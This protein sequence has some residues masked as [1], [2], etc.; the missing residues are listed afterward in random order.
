MEDVHSCTVN[1]EA[2][3]HSAQLLGYIYICIYIYMYIYIQIYFIQL[4]TYVLGDTPEKY[5]KPVTSIN[6][7]V[8]SSQ[9]SPVDFDIHVGCH[10]HGHSPG[11][12]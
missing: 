10:G 11:R 9:V 4:Y 8:H 1:A 5:N 12:I 7:K 2:L 6:Y 3:P